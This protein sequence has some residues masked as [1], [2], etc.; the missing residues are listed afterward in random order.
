M[1]GAVVADGRTIS[2]CLPEATRADV[3]SMHKLLRAHAIPVKSGARG[4]LLLLDISKP[5]ADGIA[6]LESLA[7]RRPSDL[8]C[9]FIAICVEGDC[10][11]G[12][13]IMGK[14]FPVSAGHQVGRYELLAALMA[15]CN[16]VI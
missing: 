16:L 8:A 10:Q 1:L 2:E 3:L 6:R 9:A 14:H 7:G 4:R 5:T 12:R 13:R 15:D 11:I